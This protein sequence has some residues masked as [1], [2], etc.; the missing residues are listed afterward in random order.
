[1]LKRREFLQ[2][3]LAC[4]V[5]GSIITS[6][7]RAP[8]L[9]DQSGSKNVLFYDNT[10]P[11]FYDND[12]TN[13]Y[14]DWYLMALASAGDINYVGISTSSS[15]PPY[16]RHMT[17]AHRA[18]QVERR[19]EI[20]RRGRESGFRNIPDPVA[21]TKG[22]LAKPT[23]G[24][25]DET[26]PLDSPGSRQIIEQ[27][28]KA[29]PDKPLVLCVGGPLTVAADAY[30]LDNSIAEKLIVAFL[31]NYN[32]GMYGFNGWSDGWAAYIV[33][34]RLRLVQFTVQ[35]KSSAYIPKK[36]LFELPA[37]SARDFMIASKPDVAAPEGDA[38]GPPAIALM[39]QDF[40]K[41]IKRVSFGGWKK[42]DGHEMPLFKND[43]G[44]RAVVVTNADRSVATKEWFRA[45]KNPKAWHAS[46]SK[47]D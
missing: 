40:I 21:G 18:R 3:S 32:G 30:L 25:K 19:R 16:N 13:D 35:S 34:E 23:S 14:V 27:A 22:H 46:K 33:L 15:I 37:N 11:V 29:S 4:A 39:R 42:R 44:G 8:A 38:D 2:S 10:N 6:L 12:W 26:K 5:T 36:R 45:M 17:A 20:V 41:K 24:Q 7:N 43:P 9:E 47:S 31:D 28:H 1:M